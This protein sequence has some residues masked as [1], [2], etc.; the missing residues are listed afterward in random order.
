MKKDYSYE[1]LYPGRFI[2]A[3]DFKDKDVTL[4][5]KDVELES[6]KSNKGEK[7]KCVVTFNE[8]PKQLVLN[9]TNAECVKGMFGP[10]PRAWLGKRVTFFP[11]MGTYFGKRQPACRVRGSPDLEKD[12]DITCKVGWDDPFTV[13]M[14]R[15]GPKPANGRAPTRPAPIAAPVT[16]DGEPPEDLEPGSD[17][18]LPPVTAPAQTSNRVRKMPPIQAEEPPMPTDEELF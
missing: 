11:E 1:E 10:K 17:L 3:V 14:R 9:K 15:T 18:E 5:I 7:I 2:N 13:T 16:T 6:L 4:T 12:K 8:T